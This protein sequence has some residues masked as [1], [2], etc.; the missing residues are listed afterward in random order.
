MTNHSYL[1]KDVQS[2]NPISFTRQLDRLKSRIELLW[3]LF[4]IFYFCVAL[5]NIYIGTSASLVI[6]CTPS[7]ALHFNCLHMYLHLYL[8][9][10]FCTCRNASSSS[11]VCLRW[12]R[13]S[14]AC[15]LRPALHLQRLHQQQKAPLP[16]L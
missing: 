7:A 12:L 4:T 13:C 5:H 10:F 8:Y 11:L 15:L 2:C 1:L 6:P 9:L 14:F 16:L 3:C